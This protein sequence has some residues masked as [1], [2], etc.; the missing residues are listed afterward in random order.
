[1]GTLWRSFRKRSYRAGA[2]AH[3]ELTLREPFGSQ[4]DTC[5]VRA[6][7]RRT[8]LELPITSR[9]VSVSGARTYKLAKKFP[10]GIGRIH[11]RSSW[12][13][14]EVTTD[15]FF[16]GGALCRVGAGALA[17]R[18]RAV[19]PAHEPTLSTG[20]SANDRGRL[21]ACSSC[22]ALLE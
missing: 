12:A 6:E 22:T 2:K 3:R 5:G 11:G 15:P 13:P 16:A 19:G 9:A 10:W 14:F 21:R 17:A 8:S 7:P 18:L 20:I 4:L 1:M